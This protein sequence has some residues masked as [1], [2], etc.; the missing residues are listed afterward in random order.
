[1]ATDY[2]IDYNRGSDSNDGLTKDTA[3]ASLSKI[4]A[5]TAA[6]PDDF[7]LLE[8]E[9]RWKLDYA[10]GSDGRVAPPT[11]WTG[12]RKHPVV[13]SGYTYSSQETRKPTVVFHHEIAAS[14][15]VYDA[16]LNGWLWT[17]PSAHINTMGLLR[18]ADT[19][20]ANSVDQA[21]AIEGTTTGAVASVDGRFNKT[22]TNNKLL[23]YAPAGKNPTEYYGKVIY[24]P[25]ATGAFTLSSGRKCI[26]VQDI[27][28]EDTGAGVLMYSGTAVEANF[29]ARRLS[30]SRVSGMVSM[31]SDTV[32]VLEAS[33]EDCDISD[34]GAIGIHAYSVG[35]AG[36]KS[37]K[38]TRNRLRRGGH[39][40]S[41][42]GIYVHVRNSARE[43]ITEVSY[44]DISGYIWGTRDKGYDGCG[45]YCETGAD[46][47]LVFGNV[48]RDQYCAF[49]DNSGR[50]NNWMGNVASNVR[51]G[52]RLS[53]QQDN[54]Q[55]HVRLINNT[56][57]CGNL[58]QVPSEWGSSQGSEYPGVWMYKSSGGN[59]N[60][61]ATNNLIANLG[62]GTAR[63][64]F[65]LPDRAGTMSLDGNWLYG[66]GADT[67]VASSNSSA[68]SLTNA[69]TAD[70]RPYLMADGALYLPATATVSSVAADNPLAK[71]GSYVQGVKLKN[72]RLRPGFCPIGAYQA[73]LPRSARA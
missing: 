15:W 20:L 65:G 69:G 32:G 25:E 46:G 28:F 19:W 37:V 50:A 49:Q 10:V 29:V 22:S 52:F 14:E 31:S 54:N 51:L 58:N 57:L 6:G 61:T 8:G 47:V 27:H 39:L 73:V 3:W 24:S 30:G 35:G 40:Q 64:A 12:N 7:F 42:G 45:I 18:L 34:F 62:A 63:A 21:A 16:N 23:L 17:A 4:V 36:M 33:V 26:V 9:S 53:D 72:G 41:Q 56:I 66:F 68:G 38:I 70:P 55:S 2:F 71:A 60:V 13:I 59:L 44:N 5:V 1:M 48:V 43:F 67:M 11:S